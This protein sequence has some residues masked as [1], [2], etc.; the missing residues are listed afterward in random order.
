MVRHQVK[1]GIAGRVQV[2]GFTYLGLMLFMVI[3]GIGLAVT[4]KVWHTEL[5]RQKEQELLFIGDQFV[6]AIRSYYESTPTGLKQYPLTL[7]E[8][9]LDQRFPGPKHHLRRLYRDPMTGSVEW[10][11]VKDQERIIGVYSLSQNHPLMKFHFTTAEQ[12]PNPPASYADWRFIYKAVLTTTPNVSGGAVSPDPQ[13]PAIPGTT[14]PDPLPG[15]PPADS[16][17]PEDP[18]H[19]QA[20]IEHATCVM[21]CKR[22][23]DLCN[24][25]NFSQMQ[26]WYACKQH[27]DPMPLVTK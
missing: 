18:C 2:Y 11:L 7:Q 4:G 17:E 8:L 23:L 12:D 5:Q 24:D 10:G 9:L 25:C 21:V 13:P 26:R 1:S 20:V 15:E 22:N 14:S 16:G 27:K 3:A 19:A 6:Q